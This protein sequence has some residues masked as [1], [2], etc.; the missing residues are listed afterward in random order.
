M[1]AGD[2]RLVAPAAPKSTHRETRQ[3]GDEATE[4]GE[5]RE[6]VVR[7]QESGLTGSAPLRVYAHPPRV[8]V[9][10]SGALL[11]PGGSQQFAVRALD[12]WSR[13]L[14]T[15][16]VPVRWSCP[17][18]LGQVDQ[19]GLFHAAAAPARG[20]LTA[21]IAGTQ[22]AIPVTVGTG[23][24]LL[25]GF[26][27]AGDLGALT[28]P[29]VRGR[30]TVST[31]PPGVKGSVSVVEDT[32]QQGHRCLRLEYDF[33]AGQGTR[34]VCA[35]TS[36]PLGQPMAL[37]LWVRGDG[38]GAWLRAR[39]RDA[40]GRAQIVDFTR[41]LGRLDG[42]Q[43]L[44][45]AIPPALAGPLTLEALYLVEPDPQAQP[46]GAIELD[47]LAGDYALAQTVDGRR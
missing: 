20:E 33:S 28:G 6:G 9:I 5:V 15:D 43:E 34:A 46:K 42:W 38:G 32:P 14:I 22:V 25:D 16:G 21:E 30:W 36:L 31:V 3:G 2:S 23:T 7:V 39:L 35:N 29:G 4:I 41:H 45:T 17:P 18:E 13:P 10:P 19:T 24:R 47:G 11:P 1:G 40:H 26:E 12:E 37:R 44:T 27:V 8:V